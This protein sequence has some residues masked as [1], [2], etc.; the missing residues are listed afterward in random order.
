MITF[1]QIHVQNCCRF[2]VTRAVLVSFPAEA[3][4]LSAE[5]SFQGEDDQVKRA[6]QASLEEEMAKLF[7]WWWCHSKRRRR[8]HWYDD[9]LEVAQ[10]AAAA[11]SAAT[12]A[13]EEVKNDE[14]KEDE[15][16]E[17]EEEE[18]EKEIPWSGQHLRSILAGRILMPSSSAAVVEEP[19]AEEAAPAVVEEAAAAAPAAEEVPPAVVE[20]AAAAAPAAEETVPPSVEKPAPT[21]AGLRL[22]ALVATLIVALLS[23]YTT[24]VF[25]PGSGGRTSVSELNVGAVL[26]DDSGGCAPVSV[27]KAGYVLTVPVTSSPGPCKPPPPLLLLPRPPLPPLPW[28]FPLLRPWRLRLAQVSRTGLLPVPPVAHPRAPPKLLPQR[29]TL[30]PCFRGCC[31]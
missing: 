4:L 15:E 17:E 2:V 21:A 23:S 11:A 24:P 6:V 19:A 3:S 26:L 10:A 14:E 31:P 27:L 13:P 7:P 12:P 20:E 28:S 5:S 29:S 1:S 18:E 22:L 9:F 16:E 30:P 8:R 25:Y